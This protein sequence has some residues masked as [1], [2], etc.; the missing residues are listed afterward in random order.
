MTRKSPAKGKQDQTVPEPTDTKQPESTDE[1]N[2]PE[3]TEEPTIDLTAFKTAVTNAL[4]RRDESNG[5]L[6]EDDVKAVVE[7][8]RALDGQKP[9]NAAKAELETGMKAAVKDLDIVLAK[10]YVQLKDALAASAPKKE[11]STADP[12]ES[13]VQTQYALTIAAA[14][15]EGNV[16]EG[17]AEDWRDR[18]DK[19]TDDNLDA[20]N[21][22]KEWFEADEESRGD[23]P[24]APAAV[25]KAFT[26][27]SKRV[28]KGGGSRNAG[29]PRRDVKKH[30]KEVFD[31][32]EVGTTL[33]VNQI[34]KHGSSDYG[35][36][37]P[38]AGAVTQALFPKNGK[39][40][41]IEGIEAHSD[42]PRR[43]TKVA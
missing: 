38:S 23:E 9:R 21:A 18:L 16:P 28:G 42:K 26:Y 3:S 6:A 14:L 31:G 4:S 32:V 17:V 35:N 8:Y 34:S 29:G 12:T 25:R 10:S 27:A 7:A 20:F 11:R 33:T 2:A 1:G 13:F 37:G 19:F 36:T 39:G 30:I 15:H 43:A 41:G 22:Y 24:E 5:D 40:H